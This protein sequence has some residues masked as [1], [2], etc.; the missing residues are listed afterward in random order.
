MGERAGNTSLAEIITCMNDHTQFTNDINELKLSAVSEMVET[1]SG[2]SVSSNTPLVGQDVFTQ[3]AGIHADGDAKGK[4]YE[5]NLVPERFGRVRAYALGKLAGKASLDHNLKN[6]GISLSEEN[7]NKVLKRVVE[8]GDKKQTIESEDLLMIISDV[9]KSPTDKTIRITQYS[10]NLESTAKPVAMIV[11]DFFGSTL[12][13][14]SE[15]D[16]GFDALMKAIT[17]ALSSESLVL[18]NLSDFRVRI[19]PGGKTEALVETLIKWDTQDIS[20]TFVTN[21]VDTD[22]LGAAVIAVE[23]MLNIMGS[24]NAQHK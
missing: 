1:F 16:G 5:T 24:L 14:S 17:K 21:G 3:T 15:G 7:R 9:L 13:G 22:Q 12:K 18:P 23:K 4:L 19:P 20:R 8:L 10:V 2:K 11:I 6:L